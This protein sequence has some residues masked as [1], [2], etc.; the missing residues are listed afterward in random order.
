M[1]LSV[2]GIIPPIPIPLANFEIELTTHSDSTLGIGSAT[3]I[4]TQRIEKIPLVL[5]F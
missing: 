4:R 3:P 5:R 2:F 1:R